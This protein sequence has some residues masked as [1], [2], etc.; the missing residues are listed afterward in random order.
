[1]L[2]VHHHQQGRCLTGNPDISRHTSPLVREAFATLTDRGTVAYASIRLGDAL[3]NLVRCVHLLEQQDIGVVSS[4]L[5]SCRA[6]DDEI[7]DRLKHP[8]QSLRHCLYVLI[9]LKIGAASHFG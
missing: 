4:R 1:V 8:R 7:C 2:S 9:D 6:A 3:F 5:Q